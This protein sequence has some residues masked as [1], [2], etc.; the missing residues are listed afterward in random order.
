[1]QN[2]HTIIARSSSPVASRQKKKPAVSFSIAANPV[3]LL[4]NTNFRLVAYANNT[5]STHAIT[6]LIAVDIPIREQI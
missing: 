2:V 3:D 5:E 1:M 4:K 6:V